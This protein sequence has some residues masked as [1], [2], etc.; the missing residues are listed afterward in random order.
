[1]YK[2]HNMSAPEQ[3][4]YRHDGYFKY[5]VS[6]ALEEAFIGDYWWDP[7][8]GQSCVKESKVSSESMYKPL[9]IIYNEGEVTSSSTMD[10]F[11]SV[12]TALTTQYRI[13]FGGSVIFPLANDTYLPESAAGAIQ[14][15]AWQNTVCISAPLPWLLLP[16]M[17]TLFTAV[18]LGWTIAGSLGA[19]LSRPVWKES[20][21]PFLFHH[22]IFKPEDPVVETEPSSG[23]ETE[24]FGR[25][26]STGTEDGNTAL[27]ELKE[28]DELAEKTLVTARWPSDEGVKSSSLGLRQRWRTPKEDVGNPFI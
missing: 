3:C 25:E 14:G 4:I 16:V 24:P 13:T 20:L 23:K 12:A 28:M 21:L 6:Q 26:G 1:L 19:N 11:A 22:D 15:I 5:S 2:E 27:L 8:A 17:V 10:Y 18:V 7:I 9:E